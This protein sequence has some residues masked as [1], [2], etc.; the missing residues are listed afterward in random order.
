MASRPI[1]EN[2]MSLSV[3]PVTRMDCQP[4]VIGIHYARRWPS[5]TYAFGLFDGD[6]L[7]G[8]VT[9]GTPMSS[10]LKTGLAGEENAEHVIELNRLVLRH[11]RPN[12]A[13]FLVGRSLREL[14]K[15]GDFIVISYADTTQ[16]HAGFV[17]QACNFTYH[18]LSA[19]FTDVKVRGQEHLHHASIGDKFRHHP[20]RRQ[21]MRE[22]FGD[23]LI[24]EERAR[25][26]RYVYC[27]GS[28]RFVR[29]AR[30][31]IRYPQEPYPKEVGERHDVPRR[32]DDPDQPRLL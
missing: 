14:G 32:P 29:Q 8:V 3:R 6:E 28:R 7:V 2:G 19:R 17:Y 1:C 11:N 22:H 13:S 18:G 24:E 21:V 5:M 20:N 4:F 15:L 16:G 27:V 30:A 9:Y 23:D 31:A 26:H 12:E 25:K 10:T